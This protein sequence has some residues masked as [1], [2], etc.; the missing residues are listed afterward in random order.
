MEAKVQNNLVYQIKN[1]SLCM[2][3]FWY[4]FCIKHRANTS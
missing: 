1:V 3:Y 4:G 2:C